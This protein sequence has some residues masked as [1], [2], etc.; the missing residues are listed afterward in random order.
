MHDRSYLLAGRFLIQF[1]IYAGITVNLLS[2]NLSDYA[3]C[4]WEHASVKNLYLLSLLR[5]VCED[6]SGGQENIP[7]P[8]TNVVD[9]P[10][11]APTGKLTY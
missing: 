3:I 9:D 2:I 8:A 5:L 10:P 7:I 6:I 11:V 1:P 4:L